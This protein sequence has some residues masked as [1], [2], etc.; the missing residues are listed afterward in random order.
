[1]YKI[2]YLDIKENNEYD[3]IIEKTLKKCFEVEDLSYEKLL[4][5]VILTNPENIEI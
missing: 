5:S 2:E 1:M 4:V 3:K